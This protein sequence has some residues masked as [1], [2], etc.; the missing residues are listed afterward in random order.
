MIKATP[1]RRPSENPLS[2]S[3]GH[4]PPQDPASLTGRIDRARAKQPQ[5]SEPP[6]PQGLHL[7]VRV[8][9]ELFAPIVVGGWIGWMIDQAWMTSP[10]FL[11]IFFVMGF[12]AGL[13]GVVRSAKRWDHKKSS[14]SGSNHTS[15][16]TGPDQS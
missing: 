1:P 4:A 13:L 12:I 3:A 8:L 5:P 7:G 2:Q 15:D 9:V 10:W 6:P 14:S 16:H 11:L